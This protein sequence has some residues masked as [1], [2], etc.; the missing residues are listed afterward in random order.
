MNSF[1]I[2]EET[3]TSLKIFENIN[4][5]YFLLTY[6]NK[7]KNYD[8][9]KLKQIIYKKII[10]KDFAYQFIHQ[11]LILKFKI[12]NGKINQMFYEI[13]CQEI[14][15]ELNNDN[16]DNDNLKN[17]VNNLISKV[18]LLQEKILI[19]EETN[20]ELKEKI[21]ILEET[22]LE[23]KEINSIQEKINSKQEDKNY[24]FEQK[25]IDSN[26]KL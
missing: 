1:S 26:K 15:V 2:T 4:K 12:G 8:F 14:F 22:N 25:I 23:L 11:S 9:D 17:L 3:N 16:D 24:R 18:I 19:L 6:P 20:L 5:R 21:L 7:F 10:E 13:E